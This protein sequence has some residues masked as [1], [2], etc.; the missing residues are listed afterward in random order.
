MVPWGSPYVL[1]PKNRRGIRRRSGPPSVQSMS[2]VMARLCRRIWGGGRRRSEPPWA[3]ASMESQSRN[4]FLGKRAPRHKEARNHVLLQN[5]FVGNIFRRTG[6][7]SP[8]F[9]TSSGA[10]YCKFE[11]MSPVMCGKYENMPTYGHIVRTS[12]H[13]NLCQLVHEGTASL[14]GQ[15]GR[16][17]PCQVTLGPN[18]G[19]A[20]TTQ[21]W[22]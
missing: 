5:F 12:W 1:Q 2:T 11:K 4:F 17:A 7:R 10:K 15:T 9:T 20:C 3:V 13:A 14:Q 19:E 22:T 16:R 18:D 6:P 21:C 8:D